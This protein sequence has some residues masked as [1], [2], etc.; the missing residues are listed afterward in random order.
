MYGGN[1]HHAC[2][3]GAKT[4]LAQSDRNKSHISG[5]P[6]LFGAEITLGADEDHHILPRPVNTGYRAALVPRQQLVT[7]GNATNAVKRFCKHLLNR[8]HL[9][10]A[11]EC[12]LE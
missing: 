4:A 9:V 8:S 1:R 2:S 3:L 7:L 6:H 12:G 10:Y 11:R 5:Q